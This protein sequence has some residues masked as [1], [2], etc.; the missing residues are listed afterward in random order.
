M[1]RKVALMLAIMMF[2]NVMI[3]TSCGKEVTS[4]PKGSSDT[5]SAIGVDLYGYPKESLVDYLAASP[6][7]TP[8]HLEG[9]FNES[10]YLKHRQTLIGNIMSLSE[11]MVL[12]L[13]YFLGLS[14]EIQ[15][16]VLQDYRELSSLDPE[17]E[18]VYEMV[19]DRY[20][21]QMI[22][23]AGLLAHIKAIE[24]ANSQDPFLKAWQDYDLAMKRLE[25]TA[26]T[27]ERIMEITEDHQLLR[28]H[29]IEDLGMVDNEYIFMEMDNIVA[30]FSRDDLYVERQYL[31]IAE[32]IKSLDHLGRADAFATIWAVEDSISSVESDMDKIDE[33]ERNGILNETEIQ[34][35]ESSLK[36]QK[37][38]FLGH[39]KAIL[40]SNGL[41]KELSYDWES[42]E[43]T[44]EALKVF[45]A[46]LQQYLETPVYAQGEDNLQTAVEIIQEPKRGAEENREVS[47]GFFASMKEKLSSARKST[48]S[49]VGKYLE[50]ASTVTYK[51]SI[52]VVG[53]YYGISKE[54]IEDEKRD[55]EELEKQRLLDG[56]AGSQVIRDGIAWLEDKEQWIGEIAKDALGEDSRTARLIGYGS[57]FAIQKYTSASKSMMVLIDSNATDEEIAS[58]F[59]DVVVTSLGELKVLENTIGRLDKDKFEKIL[60]IYDDAMDVFNISKDLIEDEDNRYKD[61]IISRLEEKNDQMERVE[62][63]EKAVESLDQIE[64]A[65]R[66]KTAEQLEFLYGEAGSPALGGYKTPAF[67]SSVLLI[68]KDIV[69]AGLI[70]DMDFS[71]LGLED[72]TNPEVDLGMEDKSNSEKEPGLEEDR[73]DGAV[74]AVEN[75]SKAEDAQNHI[76]EKPIKDNTEGKLTG[77]Y[78]GVI[79]AIDTIWGSADLNDPVQLVITDNQMVLSNTGPSELF[80]TSF[81]FSHTIVQT[82]INYVAGVG[83]IPDSYF[84]LLDGGQMYDSQIGCRVTGYT[85]GK[86]K[87]EISYKS[88]F[89]GTIYFEVEK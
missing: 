39:R 26:L 38:M 16:E 52:T 7:Y 55:A 27:F 33:V 57:K 67:D 83:K 64:Q 28:D 11:V 50:K 80:E 51:A 41:G 1:K 8:D 79:Y 77:T 24:E 22:Q 18:M 58:A 70:M 30:Q 76:E 87:L 49:F 5:E 59:S 63:T 13:E 40:E 54:D 68:A 20:T 78:T 88:E 19:R 2:F 15:W 82:D 36:L 56:S 44:L 4:N 81:S 35:L 45:L 89:A 23:T 75:N 6:F 47:K 17:I 34:L 46:Q 37:E 29:V 84:E 62:L 3:F 21:S 73:Y 86:G 53:S 60:G 42:E 48:A 10:E 43:P 74:V 12:N 66:E 71:G 65:S 85:K 32:L 61:Q 69:E 14:D 72:N 9:I 31:N 25:L